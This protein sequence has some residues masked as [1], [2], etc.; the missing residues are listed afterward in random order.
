M[1]MV[2]IN[3]NCNG[4]LTL[5]QSP[6]PGGSISTTTAITM[7]L[8]DGNGNT[9][10]C[11]FNVIPIDVLAPTIT[12]PATTDMNTDSGCDYILQDLTGMVTAAVNCT[13]A[14]SLVYS[15]SPSPTTPLAIG[16]NPITITVTD[17][18]GNNSFCSFDI[19]VLDQVAPVASVCPPIKMFMLTHLVW[20]Y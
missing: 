13:P 10:S 11:I 16:L 3:D 6:L 20:D 4:A 8:D 2:T 14:I 5:T 12:C 7:L 1:S 19:N 17:L 15:Q 18:I 9:S